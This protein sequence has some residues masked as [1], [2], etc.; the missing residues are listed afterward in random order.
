VVDRQGGPATTTVRDEPHPGVHQGDEIYLPLGN[1]ILSSV[2][3]VKSRDPIFTYVEGIDYVVNRA[4]GRIDILAGSGVRIDM[5]GTGM[6]LYISYVVFKD[7]NI[8]Y[9]VDSFAATSELSLLDNSLL[10]G[11]TYSEDQNHVIS[12]PANNSLRGSR[13]TTLY[14]SGR[15]DIFNYRLAYRN[16]ETGNQS[17]Q[18]I[19][20]NGRAN[21]NTYNSTFSLDARNRY[22]L[23]D[24]TPVNEGYSENSAEVTAAYV[25]NILT[26]MKF[27]LQANFIDSRSDLRGAK[28]SLSLQSSYSIMLN[29]TY[30]T[31]SGQTAWTFYNG[32]IWRDDSLHIDLTRYF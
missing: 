4:L 12:G 18:A 24:A 7:T 17:Y 10:L 8:K 25:R 15:H 31:M 28:D 6:D 21:W 14:A 27:T 26:N 16:V 22:Y 3:S 13:S 1:G 9:S 20:G 29:K 19:E 2:I 11:A 5:A 30:I 32:G 23:Y